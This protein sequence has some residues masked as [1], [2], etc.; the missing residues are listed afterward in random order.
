MV[1]LHP[2]SK[3][4]ILNVGKSKLGNPQHLSQFIL[5]VKVSR[6]VFFVLIISI[7]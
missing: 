4:S 2:D 1:P 7:I 6:L 5:R 3:L